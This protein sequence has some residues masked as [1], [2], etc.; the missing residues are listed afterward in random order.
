MSNSSSMPLFEDMAVFV[1]VC[2]AGS[3]SEAARLLGLTPS[4]VSRSVGRLESAMGTRLLQRT[5]RKLALSESG[6]AALT[7]AREMV[8]AAQSV[9]EVSH[10]FTREA[11]GVIR[12]SVPKAVGYSVIHPHVVDFLRQYPEIDVQLLLT[13]RN[14]DLVSD[15]VDLAIRITNKPPPG[16]KGRRLLRID[17]LLCA[18]PSY[19]AKHGTPQSPQQLPEHSCI[20][21]GEDP[22]DARWK[23]KQ[24]PQTLTVSVHGRYAAN[25]TMVRMEAALQDVG[26]A[27]LPRFTAQDALEDGRLIAVLPDWQFLN[28]YAGDAWLLYP[29]TRHLAPK[30]RVWID[31]LVDRITQSGV[32]TSEESPAR[33]PPGR[34][35]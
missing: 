28:A 27:S 7:R 33:Q 29:P 12:M 34:S 32:C 26:I 21:L 9:M 18:S 10:K 23:F 11:A 2:D 16:L 13:D 20:R 8:Q 31:F 24:G 22:A 30:I 35:S 6:Q 19:L 15:E 4:A 3:F 17:H 5:T 1:R 14:I 25:H